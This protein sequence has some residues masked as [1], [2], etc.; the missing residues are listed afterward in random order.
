M[1][2]GSAGT[3][4][5]SPSPELFVSVDA[6]NVDSLLNY[7]QKINPI[8]SLRDAGARCS[9]RS[10]TEPIRRMGRDLLLQDWVRMYVQVGGGGE[11]RKGRMIRVCLSFFSLA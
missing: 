2:E 3:R 5:F 9:P 8:A 7:S 10:A 1:S 11:N 4:D 6:Y